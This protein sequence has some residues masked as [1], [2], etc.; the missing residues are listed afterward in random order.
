M[1]RHDDASRIWFFDLD[2]TLHD[3]SFQVFPAINAN[4]NVY[5]AGVLENAGLASDPVSVNAARVGYLRRYGATLLG[6]VRHHQV[7]PAA[8]LAAAHAFADL[9]PMLRA[10]P[11]L[12]PCL[13]RLPG[14]KILLTNAPKQYSTEVMQH[15]GLGPQFTHHIAIEAM[16]VHRRLQPKPS[17][18]LLRKLLAQHRVPAHH[19]VLVEDTLATLKVAKALG[20]RT[21]WMTG[22]LRKAETSAPGMP[23]G[24][25]ADLG[26]TRKRPAYVDVKVQ[27]V[28]QLFDSLSRLFP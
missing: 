19:C 3:A 17:K 6:M 10:E 25:A 8:F 18:S 12:V 4:M 14:R 20:M 1:V 2:N 11:G 27:S 23:P 7:A 28:K 5:I 15:F 26:K 16:H 9:A 24:N 21:V 13:A 22:Y